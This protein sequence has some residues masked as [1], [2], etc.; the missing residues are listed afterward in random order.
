MFDALGI[1]FI[2]LVFMDYAYFHCLG[3]HAGVM[4]VRFQQHAHL[5]QHVRSHVCPQNAMRE[6][7]RAVAMQCRRR[8]MCR[9]KALR[10]ALRKAWRKTLRELQIRSQ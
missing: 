9:V 4:L 7:W 10:K 3:T 8:T 5:Q 2:F 6:R 1:L